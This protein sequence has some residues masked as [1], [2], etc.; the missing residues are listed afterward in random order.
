MC[1]KVRT[2]TQPFDPLALILIEDDCHSSS[3]SIGE[4]K[5]STPRRLLAGGFA[6]R[7]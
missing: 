5:G 7:V 3:V 1:L 4:R 2:M 6:R